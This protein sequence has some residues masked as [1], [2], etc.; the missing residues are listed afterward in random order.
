MAENVQKS[1]LAWVV[2]GASIALILVVM[3]VLFGNL[4]GN[5]GFED[6]TTTIT[7]SNETIAW[8][9]AT[10]V[11]LDGYNS[12]WSSITATR[13]FNATDN[14]EFQIGNISISSIGVVT[15]ASDTVWEGDDSVL[16]SYTYVH[17]FDSVAELDSEAV[18][19]N[20]TSAAVNTA[21][22]LP[23]VGTITGVALLIMILIA[24]LVFA[25]RRMTGI[26]SG[27]S[28]SFGSIKDASF[29]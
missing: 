29:G 9:N 19:G 27:G 25:I 18:I 11:T 22:Q 8:V 14:T 21:A 26:N 12:T 23:T 24:L 7:V 5:L 16:L 2:V 28:E 10:G 1:I 6:D 13:S 17:T 3:L 20:Y 15:N 4:S